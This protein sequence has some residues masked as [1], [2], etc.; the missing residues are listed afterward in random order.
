M[1][2]TIDLPAD[3]A[4]ALSGEAALLGLSLPDYALRVLAAA[5]PAVAPVRNGADLVAHWQAEG[6]VGR[7][8]D[9]ADSQSHARG[10]R[11]RAERRGRE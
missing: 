1:G 5:R 9:I 7:R 8:P 11:E 2:L 10:L 4:E 6:V 3:L